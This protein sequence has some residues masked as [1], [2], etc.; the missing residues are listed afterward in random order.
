MMLKLINKISNLKIHFSTTQ[1][2]FGSFLLTILLGALLLSLPIAS[3]ANEST[4][5][6]SCLFTATSSMCVTG[7]IVVD[8][9]T[10][11]SF[12][13]QL[14]III[15]IQIGGLGVILMASII[16]LFLGQKINFIQRATLQEALSVQ[17]VG[18][19]IKLT[20][21]IL[22]GV[23]IFELGGA[24]LLF[25]SFIKDFDILTAVWYSIFHSISAFCNAGFDLM[26]VKTPFSSL[27]YYQSNVLVNVVIMLLIVIGGL[28][29]T[30]WNNI[31]RDKTNF[32]KWT[33]QTKLVVITTIILIV[34]PAIYFYYFEFN[35]VNGTS[36]V[37]QSLFQSVTTRTAGFN[38]ADFSK[39]TDVGEALSII[40]MLI[41]GSP[42][43]TA[44][45]MKTTTFIVL[46]VSTIAIFKK[47]NEAHIFNRRVEI[48][49]VKNA[50]TIFM[51]YLYLF[52]ICGFII[53]KIENTTLMETFFEVASAIGTVGLSHGITAGLTNISK[54]I[55][56]FLMF[57]G[58]VGGLTF[59]YSIMP[60][61][62][63]K[64]GYI[65]EDVTVG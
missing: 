65:K 30:V 18:G 54:V 33:L 19:I 31:Y 7:L 61:L 58:R 41:G 2:I 28:G 1:T 22:K 53:C 35:N 43:S 4:D 50:I 45:G 25:I 6:L 47:E 46:I 42:G 48:Q 39:M 56:M 27:T 8:T 13:G 24:V 14:V 16:S 3:N 32:R 12:F 49:V 52:V 29:F 44:G 51:M 34:L 9:A 20:K 64:S 15:L 63:K 62:D 10:H 59:I 17:R 21:F 60:T 37:L 57:F 5:L 11:W 26:G 38:T 23:L 40:L 36:R 55:L